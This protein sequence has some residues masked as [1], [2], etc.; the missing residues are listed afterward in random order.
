MKDLL[1]ANPDYATLLLHGL[2]V[3]AKLF[4]ISWVLA[5]ILA[6]LLMAVRSAAGPWAQRAVW[7]FVEYH[8]N[9]PGLVQIFVWYFGVPQLLPKAMQQ[10]VNRH[11]GEFVLSCIA[12]TLY[13]AA[14][15]S[16][17]LRSGL[18]SLPRGQADAARSLGMNYRQSLMHILLPQALRAALPPLVNQT[19]ALFKATSLAMTVGVADLMHATRQIENETYRTFE[20]FVIA[21]ACYLAISWLIMGVGAYA[22]RRFSAARH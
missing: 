4:A 3:T 10:W 2:G 15:M 14:Y 20:A 22:S 8:R 6:S 7:L 12:L 1:L 18:R 11:D 19:L 16:E 5:M 17:D 13:A 9:V 21:S